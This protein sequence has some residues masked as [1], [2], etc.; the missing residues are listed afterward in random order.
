M[1]AGLLVALVPIQHWE[2]QTAGAFAQLLHDQR[3]LT[4]TGL[5]ALGALVPQL[6]LHLL[7]RRPG[8]SGTPGVDAGIWQRVTAWVPVVV[9][10][11]LSYQLAFLS[12]FEGVHLTLGTGVGQAARGVSVAVLSI[13][14]AGILCT[15]LLVTLA[16]LWNLGRPADDGQPRSW[17]RGHAVG[18]GVGAVYWTLLVLLILP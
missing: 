13:V 1:L 14:Q 11:F 9:A 3:V 2:P 16:V 8:P 7:A 18:L 5:L 12:V 4:I 6:I 10:G 17:R 15:G